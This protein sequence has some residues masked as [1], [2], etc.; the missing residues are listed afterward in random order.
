M[1]LTTFMMLRWTVQAG[2]VDDD[3]EM[4][5]LN[6]TDGNIVE[7]KVSNKAVSDAEFLSARKSFRSHGGTD[8]VTE[9]STVTMDC[10]SQ[11]FNMI[12]KLINEENIENCKKIFGEH[13]L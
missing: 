1:L 7:Y 5:A 4:I 11:A 10:S 8:A 6:F 2:A 3:D 12:D 13:T 9:N